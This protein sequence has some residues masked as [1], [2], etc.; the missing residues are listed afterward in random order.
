MVVISEPESPG[1][2]SS[3]EGLVPPTPAEAAPV[4]LPG[5]P[6][7]PAHEAIEA[8]HELEHEPAA[9]SRSNESV[10]SPPGESPEEEPEPPF[11]APLE[12]IDETVADEDLKFDWYIVK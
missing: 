10:P 5:A 11:A 2:Q 4:A 7:P 9:E 1:A 3:S 12:L 6:P 8:A